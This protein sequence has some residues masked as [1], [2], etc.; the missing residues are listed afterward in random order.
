MNKN[1][2]VVGASGLV[3]SQIF[4]NLKKDNNCLVLLGRKRLS[5]ENN[6]EQIIS[7]FDNL[8]NLEN[9]FQIDEVYV[10]IGHKL[11]LS[12]LIYIKKINRDDFV[13]VD[14]KY[15]KKVAEFAKRFGAKS[16]G[17]ISAIGANANSINT[18]LK[19]KGKIEEEIKLMNFEKIVIARPSHLLGKRPKDETQLIVKLFEKI[20][21]FFG[22][23]MIGPLQKFKNVE[24][25]KVAKA[26]I[27]KMNSSE[28]GLHILDFKNF[29]NF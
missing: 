17:L 5:S 25:S 21:N 10:A 8:E 19:V 28:K 11:N 13:R 29:K 7:D 4:K 24:A 15:I 1:I 26:I 18:Y 9:N 27:S 14:L 3:G 2:L 6:T 20:T 23:I 22:F 16:I 12:E